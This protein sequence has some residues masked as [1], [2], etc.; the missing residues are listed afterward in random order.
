MQTKPYVRE[1]SSEQEVERE[2]IRSKSFTCKEPVSIH[3]VYQFFK[4]VS[5][6]QATLIL[7][8][9][10][11][12]T[13]GKTLAAIVTFFLML[14]KGDSFMFILEGNDADKAIEAITDF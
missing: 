11:L 12:L 14:K 3:W 7:R 2:V 4:K 5:S 1:L 13:Y 10:G 8:K 6:Y 9:N